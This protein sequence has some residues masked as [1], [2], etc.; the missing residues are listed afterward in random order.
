MLSGLSGRQPRPGRG[1]LKCLTLSVF[2]EAAQYAMAAGRT[3]DDDVLF[4]TLGGLIG[5]VL[6]LAPHRVLRNKYTETE[7]NPGLG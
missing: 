1:V 7:A 5:R 6:S 4:N 2:I 3:V